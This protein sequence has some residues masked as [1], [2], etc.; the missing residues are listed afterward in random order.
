M[1]SNFWTWF[2]FRTRDHS[3]SAVP[4]SYTDSEIHITPRNIF[5]YGFSMGLFIIPK[6]KPRQYIII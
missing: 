2:K 1:K 6:Q 4:L 5:P 3:I